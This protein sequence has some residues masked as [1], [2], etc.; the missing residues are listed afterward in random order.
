MYGVA[1]VAT[2][3]RG[4]QVTGRRSLRVDH[5]II[6]TASLPKNS[7]LRESDVTG[8]RTMEIRSTA[9]VRSAFVAILNEFRQ[10][11]LISFSPTGVPP[12][13]WHPLTVRVKRRSLDVKARA[14]YMR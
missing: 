3:A 13:G 9:S 7:F 2:T 11:Y 6:L 12:T 10:R 5:C 8:G 1:V 14:G 4:V